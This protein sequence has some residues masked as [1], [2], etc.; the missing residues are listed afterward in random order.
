MGPELGAESLVFHSME[1][2]KGAK[3]QGK[4]G[5]ARVMELIMS[6]IGGINSGFDVYMT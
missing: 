6:Y 4:R 5:G 1:H 2:S 3:A